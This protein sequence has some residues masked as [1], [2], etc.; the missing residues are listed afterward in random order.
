VSVVHS[1]ST[2]DLRRKV[3]VKNQEIM[4]YEDENTTNMAAKSV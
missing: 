2:K 4:K 1:F 3:K